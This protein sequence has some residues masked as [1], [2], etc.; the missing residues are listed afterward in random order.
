MA[1]GIFNP[2]RKP[3]APKKDFIGATDPRNPYDTEY[4]TDTS[5]STIRLDGDSYVLQFNNVEMEELHSRLELLL[6]DV[7]K[8][9]EDALAANGVSFI[10]K[11]QY[12][13][14]TEGQLRLE[15]PTG[16]VVVYAGENGKEVDCFRRLAYSLYLLPIKD[17]LVR[18][19]AKVYKRG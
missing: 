8:D 15:T 9:H 14:L 18:N 13:E 11:P 16:F 1:K 19:K 17:I 5:K 6:K 3:E 4:N 7:I 2:F 12:P 10:P